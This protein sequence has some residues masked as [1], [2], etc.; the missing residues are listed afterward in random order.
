MSML[1]GPEIERAQLGAER[2]SSRIT[3]RLVRPRG[4][5]SLDA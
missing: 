3:G 2:S 4:K 1:E 5:F